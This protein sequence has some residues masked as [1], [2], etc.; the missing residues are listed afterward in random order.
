MNGLRAGLIGTVAVMAVALPAGALAD[1]GTLRVASQSDIRS[2]N[3]GVDR[4]GFTDSVHLNIVEGLVGYKDDLSVGPVL[5]ETVSVSDDQKVYTFTLRPGIRFHNGDTLT[6]AHVKESW[7]RYMDEATKWRCRSRFNGEDGVNVVSVETPD[8]RTVVYT[9][10]R[11]SPLFL[12][13]MARFDCGSTGIVH[14]DSVKADGSWDRPIGTGPFV[15]VEWQPGQK[16]VLDRFADYTPAEGPMDGFTGRKTVSVDRVVISVVPDAASAKAAMRAGEVDLLNIST[17]DVEEMREAGFN[18]VVQPT[19]AW[20]SF[21]IS[22]HDEFMANRALRQ[23]MAAALDVQE[24]A[25]LMGYDSHNASPIPPMSSYYTETQKKTYGF[26]PERAR[27]LLSEAGYDGEPI[28]L[29]TSRR[30]PTIFNQ[31]VVAQSMWQAVGLNIEIEVLDWG[32]QLDL[33]RSGEYQ[34]QSFGFSA[35]LDPALSWDMFS[36]EQTR[37]VWDDPAALDKIRLLMNETDSEKRAVLSDDL[38]KMFLE[39][40]P[41]IGLY[42][43][44][45]TTALSGRV[46]GFK[47]WPGGRTRFWNIA[48]DG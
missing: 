25:A 36:G 3:P 7:D 35:R 15:F 5:A 42:S 1:Q 46:S 12:K 8:E 17:S 22:R 27:A 19:P 26:D 43:Q 41:A 21:L 18:V 45:Q 6:A 47:T 38:H 40:V 4:S 11:P 44:P 48:L 39:Q 30:S 29:I 20:G 24:L 31:A 23:A 28:K 10:D 33:Y 14:R 16:I 34:V 37:K 2:T 13:D 32:A 9:I